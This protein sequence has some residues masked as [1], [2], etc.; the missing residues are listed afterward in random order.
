MGNDRVSNVDKFQC[1]IITNVVTKHKKIAP[2]FPPR[3]KNQ[4]E[5]AVHF[6]PTNMMKLTL[7]LTAI[8]KTIKMPDLANK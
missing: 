6:L 3:I 4:E 8:E 5:V 1:E 2:G 7:R